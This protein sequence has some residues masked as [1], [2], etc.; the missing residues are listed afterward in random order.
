MSYQLKKKKSEITFIPTSRESS[1]IR[2]NNRLDQLNTNKLDFS[3]KK[4]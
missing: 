1:K 2:I 4:S 3:P